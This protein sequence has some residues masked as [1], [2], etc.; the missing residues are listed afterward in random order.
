MLNKRPQR[1]DL[2]DRVIKLARLKPSQ[3]KTRG[4]LTRVQTIELIAYLETL[5]ARV[6]EGAVASN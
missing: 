3:R 6:K 1:I 4:Y 2:V 5:N